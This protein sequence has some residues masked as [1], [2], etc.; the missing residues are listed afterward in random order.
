[1]LGDGVTIADGDD[2]RVRIL[3]RIIR[4]SFVGKAAV[5]PSERSFP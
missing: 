1:M 3:A 5:V 2:K 4:S